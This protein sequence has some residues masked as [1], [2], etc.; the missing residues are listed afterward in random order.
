MRRK[1]ES[2]IDGGDI[3]TLVEELKEEALQAPNK[4]WVECYSG[5][6]EIFIDEDVTTLI[7]WGFD[8]DD[9]GHTAMLRYL[10]T[11]EQ[12]WIRDKFIPNPLNCVVTVREQTASDYQQWLQAMWGRLKKV[13]WSWKRAAWIL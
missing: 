6:G 11:E 9:P 5:R 2:L 3:E 13:R 8:R 4:G 12:I 7:L 10:L 1:W